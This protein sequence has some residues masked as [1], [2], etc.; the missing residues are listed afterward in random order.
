MWDICRIR[1]YNNKKKKYP[2]VNPNS[3]ITVF[4]VGIGPKIW[5]KKKHKS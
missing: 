3:D 1:R 4:S 5:A 2:D